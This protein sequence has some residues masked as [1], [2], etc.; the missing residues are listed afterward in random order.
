[1]GVNVGW[2]RYLDAHVGLIYRSTN[3][4]TKFLDSF[5]PR[6]IELDVPFRAHVDSTLVD[7]LEGSVW[8]SGTSGL[9]M[10]VKGNFSNTWFYG[11]NYPILL[12]F[13]S[14]DSN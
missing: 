4:E 13:C 6:L 3:E 7:D 12:E 8:T 14:T 9:G 5:A 11:E 2:D 1:M 10:E